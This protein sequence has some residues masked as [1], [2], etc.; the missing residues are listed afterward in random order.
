MYK[1]RVIRHAKVIVSQEMDHSQIQSDDSSSN[2]DDNSTE[3]E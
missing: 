2:N 1:D 3:K